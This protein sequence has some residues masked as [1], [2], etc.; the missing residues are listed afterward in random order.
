MS[1]CS[2]RGV[3][4]VWQEGGFFQTGYFAL[5]RLKLIFVH[6]VLSDACDASSNGSLDLNPR[7]LGSE[8][9]LPPLIEN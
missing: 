9:K 7:P 8:A 4:A 2:A 3:F 5:G 1:G 6:Q